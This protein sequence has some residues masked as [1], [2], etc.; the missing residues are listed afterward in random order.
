MKNILQL[1]KESGRTLLE[2]FAQVPGSFEEYR[3]QIRTALSENPPQ[4]LQSANYCYIEGCI[5]D[6]PEKVILESVTY[7][8]ESMKSLRKYY[9]A[10][11]ML[12][13]NNSVAFSDVKEVEI[14][15]AITAKNEMI[16]LS[17][18]YKP[19]NIKMTNFV[20]TIDAT[21][22][23]EPQTEAM[24]TR[25]GKRKARVTSAQKA[26]VKNENG[27]VYPKEV[28]QGSHRSRPGTNQ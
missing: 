16:Q 18:N 19:D 21:V 7:D 24:K 12:D 11:V 26:D 28:L 27:R 20:E 23:L 25:G 13:E 14:K 22:E 10:K 9:E 6:F 2:I 17:E 8:E 5:G 15:A 1:A 3:Q 4:E